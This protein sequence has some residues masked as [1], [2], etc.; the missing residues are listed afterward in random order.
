MRLPFAAG[1]LVAGLAQAEAGWLTAQGRVGDRAELA[2]FAG[3]RSVG[4]GFLRP[5]AGDAR[6]GLGLEA[7]WLLEDRVAQLSAARRWQLNQ[8]SAG[9]FS[10]SA[11][12]VGFVVPEGRFDLGLGPVVG[13]NLGLGG[14]AF[15]V[16]LGVLSGVELFVRGT[17]RFTER[18]QLGLR[19]QVGRVTLGVSGRAGVDVSP[20]QSFVLRA[21]AIFS[22][23]LLGAAPPG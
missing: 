6:K 21:D 4:A 23:G 16:Q 9:T 18:L 5:D 17:A 11:G 19:A 2:V 14:Q 12:L 3:P 20:G 13:L 10:A 8:T 15:S 1:L 7:A 22:L